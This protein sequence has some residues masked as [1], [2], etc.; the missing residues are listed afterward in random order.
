[1]CRMLSDF[2][3]VVQDLISEVISSYRCYMN[4]GMIVKGYRMR[5]FGACV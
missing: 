1:M 4:M 2:T 3:S 5:T